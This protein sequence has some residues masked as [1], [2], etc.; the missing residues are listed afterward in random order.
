MAS[1]AL[2]G[3]ASVM[4]PHT[5]G[6]VV[7]QLAEQTQ[8]PRLGPSLAA[9]VAELARTATVPAVYTVGDG[10]TIEA[11][12][13]AF[14]LDVETVAALNG[15][16]TGAGLHAGQRIRL[17]EVAAEP[18]SASSYTVAA[19]D[20]V[21]GIAAAHDVTA[22][23]LLEAN[24]LEWESIIYP[25]QVLSIPASG[26]SGGQDSGGSE[27]EQEDRGT[28]ATEYTVVSGD[29]IWSIASSHGVSVSALL[30]ANGLDDS[31]II[32]PGDVLIIPGSE[33]AEGSSGSGTADEVVSLT[34]EMR[35]NASTIVSV[36]RDLGVPDEGIVV[37]LAAAAQESGLRN[38]DHGDADS[39]G[40]FQQRPSQGWGTVEQI[41]DPVYSAT[42]FFTGV[43]GK[44]RG[45]LDVEGWQDMSVTE[46]AQAV[47]VSAYP[48]AYAAW[49]ASARAWLAEIG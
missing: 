26:E 18:A 5:T 21:I 10:D 49:E 34:E 46:A 8:R 25:G 37:A 20:T 2:L 15:L 36:G 38:L 43:E 40:L 27:D 41:M 47:Q 3:A 33:S 7:G 9:A 29:T 30:D 39:V 45:L 17:G 23:A 24:G 44:T 22:S 31:S 32:Y 42:V 6:V 35:R 28:G 13:A 14:G 1:I 19:G 16:V 12:A 48:D 11:V 4:A